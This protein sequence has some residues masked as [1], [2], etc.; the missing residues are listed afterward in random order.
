MMLVWRRAHRSPTA[1]SAQRFLLESTFRRRGT[2]HESSVDGSGPTAAQP[3]S[4]DHSARIA[5]CA[6]AAAPI[7]IDVLQL[8][9]S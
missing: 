4:I 9:V 7:A 3:R 5:R 6:L 2:S 1:L 8:N